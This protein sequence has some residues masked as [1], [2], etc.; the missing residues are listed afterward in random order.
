MGGHGFKP[1]MIHVGDQSDGRCA[2]IRARNLSND[3]SEAVCLGSQPR[4][5]KNVMDDL[6]DSAFVE[7]H[8]RL[9]SQPFQDVQRQF[10]LNGH[11]ILDY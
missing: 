1:G 11:I 3:I 9:L 10:R 7:G 5:T 8:G 2:G 6:G 4:F